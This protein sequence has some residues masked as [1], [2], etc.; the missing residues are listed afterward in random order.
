VSQTKE[1]RQAMLAAMLEERFH[2]KVH[3]EVKELPVYDLVVTKDGPKFKESPPE[4]AADPE[5]PKK[6][7]DRGNM[8]V[9]SHNGNSELTTNAVPMLD[10]VS[11]L[12]N[13]VDRTVIDKTGLKGEYDIHLKYTSENAP[14]PLPDDAPPVL[15]TAIQEQLGLKLVASKGPVNTLV[16]DHVEQPTEN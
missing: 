6:P 10:L 8:S 16:V 14:Q 3:V 4:P 5:T 13:M 12:S 7:S 9:N 1:Q 11:S 2:V 15:F